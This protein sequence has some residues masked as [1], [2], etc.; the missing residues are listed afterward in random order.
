L[1]FFKVNV[2]LALPSILQTR[3]TLLKSDLLCNKNT[4]CVALS[5]LKFYYQLKNLRLPTFLPLAAGKVS[6]SHEAFIS[7]FLHIP[8]YCF[9]HASG[10]AAGL[11]S[12]LG[13]PSIALPPVTSSKF[14][15]RKTAGAYIATGFKPNSTHYIKSF[16]ARKEEKGK[17]NWTDTYG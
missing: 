3:I 16:P 15:C 8:M 7:R 14:G 12:A 10:M 4:N 9:E 2:H 11:K 17:E 5:L 1:P 13:L 6:F